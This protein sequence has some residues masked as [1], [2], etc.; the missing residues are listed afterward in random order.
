[1]QVAWVKN[2]GKWYAF[3]ADGYMVQDWVY[4]AASDRWYYCD[5]NNGMQYGWFYSA[6]DGC[7]YYLDPSTG[8]MSTGWRTIDGKYYYF[9]DAH[10]G[11]YYQDTA[12]GKWIYANANLLRPLGSMYA[13]T[14]TPDGSLVGTDGA[15]IPQ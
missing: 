2:G 9:S 12:T 3:D 14:I 10:T 4:D 6:T 8:A 7:W 15:Y 1:M 11:T 13:G 5:A